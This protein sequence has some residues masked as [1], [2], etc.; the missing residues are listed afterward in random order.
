MRRTIE[1]MRSTID[2]VEKFRAERG[3]TATDLHRLFGIRY[4]NYHPIVQGTLEKQLNHPSY[5]IWT[6]AK[7]RIESK[8]PL[9][10]G[11]L[12]TRR[13]MAAANGVDANDVEQA[14]R[15]AHA[16]SRGI[17]PHAAFFTA[18]GAFLDL[19]RRDYEASFQ[20]LTA[21]L[22]YGFRFASPATFFF[23]LD[24]EVLPALELHQKIRG[25]RNQ[26]WRDC[27][28]G[29]LACV[30]TEL[31]G[32]GPGG[33]R[34]TEL[35]SA[36]AVQR[37]HESKT[38]DRPLSSMISRA[39]AFNATWHLGSLERGRGAVR[40]AEAES[41]S[42]SNRQSVANT[43]CEIYLTA[44]KPD[45]AWEKIRPTY[46]GARAE[47]KKL[48]ERTEASQ[49][50]VA[51]RVHHTYASLL[52]GT[53]ARVL[54]DADRYSAEDRAEDVKILQYCEQISG[55]RIQIGRRADVLNDPRISPE[56][57][58]IIL[59]STK[60]VLTEKQQLTLS[61]VHRLINSL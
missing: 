34:A 59:R 53:I 1:E 12:R 52:E 4:Q 38:V 37:I 36:G 26:P 61:R 51:G 54:T 44:G 10:D 25:P 60:P 43:Y 28:L 11:L 16:Q 19:V 3:L 57:R 20:P 15:V 29:Q 9:L 32:G 46:L 35:F 18:L 48:L 27:C 13:V 49:P 6:E 45:T 33:E 2:A 5:R 58:S 31:G 50:A 56:L 30:C 8:D 7:R 55:G 24:S 22:Y 40:R 23:A 41:D 14:L 39:E 17:G 47:L 21:V 42:S